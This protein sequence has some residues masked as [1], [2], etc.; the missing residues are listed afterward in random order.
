MIPQHTSAGESAYMAMSERLSGFSIE[1]ADTT[2]K[3]EGL[4][5]L[6]CRV[7]GDEPEF[8]DAFYGTFG[9]DI[10]GYIICND[11]G[12]AVSALTCFRCGSM[13]GLPVYV[14]YAVC[15]D[16]EYRGQG[17]AAKLTEYVKQVVTGERGSRICM[18]GAPEAEGLG[19]I[20]LVSPAEESLIKYYAGLGYREGFRVNEHAAGITDDAEYVAADGYTDTEHTDKSSA[21][22]AGCEGG[23]PGKIRT[24]GLDADGKTGY[25]EDDDYEDFEPGLTA[26][27]AN[28]AQYNRYREAFLAEVP[29]V[30]MSDAMMEFISLDGGQGS[31]LILNSG[32]AVC[33]IAG[34]EFSGAD[35]AAHHADAGYKTVILDELL[36]NPML[37]KY[38][39]EIE[40]E[41]AERLR[42]HLGAEVLIYRTPCDGLQ[43]EGGAGD[44]RCQAM[45]AVPGG[46]DIQG[47][48]GFPIE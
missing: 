13:R 28:S 44:I 9:D 39:E 16:P 18:E 41:I 21:E 12:K 6:W 17:L 48:F 25:L 47:Y 43:P 36:V 34:E 20:S 45:Y 4:R 26:V 35:Q 5:D 30:E 10:A 7:F 32:D 14:T 38:S 22:A 8:V 15:T 27:P 19:G 31:L 3:Y 42:E 33:R 23:Q 1:K 24:W 40:E 2:S 46:A 11:A 29:H 37:L